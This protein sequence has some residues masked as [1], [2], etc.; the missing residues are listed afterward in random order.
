MSNTECRPATSKAASCGCWLLVLL[1]FAPLLPAAETTFDQNWPQWRG[2]LASGV[3]P[4]G[5]P[6]TTWSETSNVK[7]KVKI[8]GSGSATPIVWDNLVFVQTAIPTG[9]KVEGAAAAA[10]APATNAT[11]AGTNVGAAPRRGGGRGG[12]GGEKPT[13]YYQFALLCLDRQTGETRWQRVLREEV[14][15]EGYFVGEG[16][17]A[18]QSPITDGRNVYAFFGSRGLACYDFEGNQKWKKD[19]GKMQIR[20][21]FG[22][23]SSAALSGNTL[24]LVWDHE[25]SSFI[26]AVNKDTG[27]EL[28]RKARE[29]KT[30]W[31]TPLIVEHEGR[32][33]IITAA[34]SKIRSYDLATGELIWECSGLF[35]NAIPSPVTADG[36]VYLMSGYSGSAL[37]AIKLGRTGDLTGTDAIIWKYNKNT[38]YVP[39]PLLYGNRIYFLK[40]NDGMLSCFDAKSG[41]P[42][43]D[44]ERLTAIPNVYASPVGASGRVYLPGRNGTTLVIKDSDTLEVLATNKLDEAFDASPAVVGN[45]LF[46]R[47]RE[48]LYCIAER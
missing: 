19:F 32:H 7:W 41:K 31:A 26:A 45:Q 37:L 10:E 27:E 6:P 36:V 14:P 48:F 30:S 39:S 24:V 16:S 38:P 28:W 46:L 5:N 42:L 9:K 15:H 43:I 29:E 1:G 20:L 12:P 23:G 13:E 2:P 4:A 3:A 40:S 21:T 47:G 34:T 17:L 18:S 8:P 25:G 33:Q 11:P 35:Q 22:E 44:A